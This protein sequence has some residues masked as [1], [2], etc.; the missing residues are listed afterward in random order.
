MSQASHQLTE[1]WQQVHDSLDGGVGVAKFGW[2]NGASVEVGGC[3]VGLGV[4]GII[5]MFFV[6][7]KNDFWKGAIEYI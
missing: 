2:L 3:I 6:W 7:Q 4:G 5:G 1:V